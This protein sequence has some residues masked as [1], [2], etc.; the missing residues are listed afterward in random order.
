MIARIRFDEATTVRSETLLGVIRQ[1][2]VSSPSPSPYPLPHNKKRIRFWKGTGL[3]PHLRTIEM[4]WS[5][6]EVPA[7]RQ[8]H[9]PPS[10]CTIQRG[11]L[12]LFGSPLARA[13]FL[14][15]LSAGPTYDQVSSSFLPSPPSLPLLPPSLESFF[16]LADSAFPTSSTL[17]SILISFNRIE[18]GASR[19][20][21]SNHTLC[22]SLRPK[23]P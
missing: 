10:V 2:Q 18:L 8:G 22:P 14:D 11:Q 15:W 3:S 4:F 17:Q 1:S 9:L 23:L 7:P 20:Q 19:R 12:A 5:L 16:P 21:T 6:D 13:V